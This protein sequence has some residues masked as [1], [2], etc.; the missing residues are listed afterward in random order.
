[1]AFIIIAKIMGKITNSKAVFQD[2]KSKLTLD[3]SEEIHAVALALMGNYYNLT[4]T[5]ILAEKEIETLNLSS[6]IAR[7]NQHEPLQYILGEADF[8]GRKFKVS[9][10]VL[11]PR[12]ETELLIREVLKIEIKAPRILDI[13]TGSGCIAITLNLEIPNSKI[14]A[15]DVS[16]LALETAKENSKKLASTV[17]FIY[18][19]FLKDNLDLEPFDMV[20][21]NP[22]YVRETEKQSMKPNVLNYEP[23]L[24]LFVPDSD[25]LLFYKAIAS[26]SKSLLKPNGKIFVEINEKFAGEIKDLFVSSGFK[27]IKIIQDLDGKDRIV[28]AQR[29]K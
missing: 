19:D 26:K 16:Q 11:I 14:C 13:G 9:P 17:K 18:T 2:I 22:P 21:S 28:I 20:V 24:A 12:P 29:E 25:P 8:Y 27:E 15:V 23:H 10:S 5:D 6:V 1:L 7:L 3:D 4:L